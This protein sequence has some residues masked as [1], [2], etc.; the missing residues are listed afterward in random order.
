MRLNRNIS[1]HDVSL[2]C[3]IKPMRVCNVCK[4]DKRAAIED[5]LVRNVPLRRISEDVG[6]SVASL[7][8]HRQHLPEKLALAE[9]AREVSEASSLLDRVENLIAECREIAAAARKEKNWPAATGALREVRSCLELLGRLSGQLQ[10]A[11]SIQFHQHAHLHANAAI[12]T[13]EVELELEIARQVGEAT[14]GFD[15]R[16]IA[17]LRALVAQPLL[18][19]ASES[20]SNVPP[21]ELARQELAA[22]CPR[23]VRI[24]ADEKC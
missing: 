7:F 5:A 6:L 13:S 19:R 24:G 15:E 14:C 10:A 3:Y 20:K 8:R 18:E 16:E 2:L 23:N 22:E 11:A 17:R 12:P 4:N 1:E 21:Q 9:R